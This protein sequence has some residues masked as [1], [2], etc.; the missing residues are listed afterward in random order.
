MRKRACGQTGG[1]VCAAG[2]MFRACSTAY[3]RLYPEAKELLLDLRERGISVYLLSNAQRLFT[4]P[5]LKMLGIYE[6]F[7]KICI[8]S[9]VG[10]CKP[11]H[12]FF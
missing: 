1:L 2:R 6:L 7:D 12:R 10:F 8:S 11:S 5:E 4:E 3:I 9:D